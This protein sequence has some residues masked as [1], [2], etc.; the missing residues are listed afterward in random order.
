MGLS[1]VAVKLMFSTMDVCIFGPI[2]EL[3]KIVNVL[4]SVEELGC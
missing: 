1:E 4:V 3:E 2:V